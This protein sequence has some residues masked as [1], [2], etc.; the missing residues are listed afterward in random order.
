M[1]DFSDKTE[2]KKVSC[3][4]ED[5]FL[6]CLLFTNKMNTYPMQ[7]QQDLLLGRETDLDQIVPFDYHDT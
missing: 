4:S 7:Q 1:L 5:F 3:L 2:I 6:Q